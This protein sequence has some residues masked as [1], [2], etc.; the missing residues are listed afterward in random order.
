MF[1]LISIVSLK[2]IFI[3]HYYLSSSGFYSSNTYR[4]HDQHHTS[5]LVEEHASSGPVSGSSAFDDGDGRQKAQAGTL[6]S[7]SSSGWVGARY[8][9][10][11]SVLGDDSQNCWLELIEILSE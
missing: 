8:T 6:D 10:E 4:F 3:Q 9:V 7:I 1:L 2:C 5:E 11:G